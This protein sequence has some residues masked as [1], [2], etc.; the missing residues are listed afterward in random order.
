MAVSGEVTFN[1]ETAIVR[2]V[3]VDN[4]FREHLIFE[5]YP[6]IA[7]AEKM[8]LTEVCEE[9]AILDGII[10]AYLRIE[11][12]NAMLRLDKLTLAGALP[13]GLEIARLSREKHLAR[14]EF[15]ISKLNQNLQK[16]GAAWV[17]GHTEV[18]QMSYSERK[19]L[20]G[21]STFPAGFEY[22]TGGIIQT[23]P[24]L[25]AASASLMV[26]KW[27]WRN[28]H[29]K[30]WISPVKNQSSCGS[31]WAFAATGATEA[32]VNLYFNRLLNLDLSEQ[33]VLSCSGAGTC[34]GGLPEYCAELYRF[35]RDRR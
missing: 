27:D 28:R 21:N 3:L 11:V 13:P 7:D 2:A 30:N 19:N 24:G 10:P 29:G 35:H 31:C 22:Y 5:W 14:N 6:L 9:T 25:K 18:S 8:S 16:K 4:N 15:K 33:D 12:K 32:Q 1:D 34:G 17:A 23:G 20:Y 26:E